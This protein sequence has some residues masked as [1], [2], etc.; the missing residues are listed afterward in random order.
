MTQQLVLKGTGFYL[1]GSNLSGT[2]SSRSEPFSLR[3]PTASLAPQKA[4]SHNHA[5][6]FPISSSVLKQAVQT[7]VHPL[8]KVHLW[9]SESP[10]SRSSCLLQGLGCAVPSLR[11]VVQGNTC[12]VTLGRGGV[13]GGTVPREWLLRTSFREAVVPSRSLQVAWL[14]S[15]ADPLSYT[16]PRSR[17]PPTPFQPMWLLPSF[18]LPSFKCSAWN[19]LHDLIYGPSYDVFSL[20]HF[21][22][23][24][25]IFHLLLAA[26]FSQGKSSL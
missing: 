14:L 4:I 26:I 15:V 17:P 5:Q 18:S 7:G 13:Q 22:Q 2:G 3:R 23:F 16:R 9:V 12:S 20:R 25:H 1:Q 11:A 8:W 19:Y 21:Y 10:S 24:P 6:K